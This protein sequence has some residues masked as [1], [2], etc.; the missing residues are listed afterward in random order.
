MSLN[1]FISFAQVLLTPLEK[2]LGHP[3]HKPKPKYGKKQL[4]FMFLPYFPNKLP[5]K[6][7]LSKENE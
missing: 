5:I 7:V 2:A 6:L 1:I 4:F 3:V